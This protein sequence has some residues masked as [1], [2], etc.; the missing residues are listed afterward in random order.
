MAAYEVFSALG[1]AG[2]FEPVRT[3]AAFGAA[4]E[5]GS[6]ETRAA[7]AVGTSGMFHVKHERGCST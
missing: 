4:G 1:A 3:G 6:L 5:A 7:G 2:R